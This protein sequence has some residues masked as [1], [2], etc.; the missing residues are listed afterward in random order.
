MEWT[1]IAIGYRYLAIRADAYVHRCCGC[2]R[3]RIRF[4]LWIHRRCRKWNHYRR[5]SPTWDERNWKVRE[6]TENSIGEKVTLPFAIATAT[7]GRYILCDSVGRRLT[8]IRC[9]LY[10]CARRLDKGFKNVFS[11]SLKW[12]NIELYPSASSC[13]KLFEWQWLCGCCHYK[14]EKCSTSKVGWR[15]VYSHFHDRD[16]VDFYCYWVN[17]DTELNRLN[18]KSMYC[19]KSIY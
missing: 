18:E 1:C 7:F 14:Y 5:T 9:M 4:C 10:A 13:R 3:H 2:R 8:D 16:C 6:R 19:S 11:R 12:D 17:F 15:S